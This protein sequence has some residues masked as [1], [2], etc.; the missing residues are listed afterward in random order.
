MARH[1]IRK[2]RYIP[3][4]HVIGEQPDLFGGPTISHATERKP[5]GAKALRAITKWAIAPWLGDVDREAVL[6][7]ASAPLPVYL[8]ACAAAKLDHAAEARD[9]YI[10]PWFRKARAY[11]ER[12]GSPWLIL[13]AK[14]GLIAPG[15]V[16]EPYDATLGKMGAPARRLWG[17]RVLDELARVVDVAAPLIVLAGRSYRAPLWPSIAP[18]AAAPMEGLAI[19]EQLAWL[20]RPTA[21]I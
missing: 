21:D 4:V 2:P 6:E 10:S 16:I 12:T 5:V 20:S 11:V 19:G 3:R 7:E 18:R 13:S 15:A 14:H 8:V 9:L 17:A 1:C